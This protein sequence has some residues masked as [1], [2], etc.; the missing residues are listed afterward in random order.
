MKGVSGKETLKNERYK[1]SQFP[2]KDIF[3][4]RTL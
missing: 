4:E 1:M 2:T 3:A